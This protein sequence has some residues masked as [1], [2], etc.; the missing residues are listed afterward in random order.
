MFWIDDRS[1]SEIMTIRQR[2]ERERVISRPMIF[3]MSLWLWLLLMCDAMMKT[4]KGQ[5]ITIIKIY[6][7]KD[8]RGLFVCM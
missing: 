3:M 2:E 4:P 1:A 6:N 8:D 5:I 7:H